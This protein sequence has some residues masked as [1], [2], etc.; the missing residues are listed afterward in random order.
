MCSFHVSNLPCVPTKLT[1]LVLCVA[2]WMLS[3]TEFSKILE[4]FKTNMVTFEISINKNQTPSQ[5]K[6]L[7]GYQKVRISTVDEPPLR[8]TETQ[9]EKAPGRF[10]LPSQDSES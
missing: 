2:N 1:L 3:E 8:K 5:R 9:K 6:Q 4:I 10:E 7:S